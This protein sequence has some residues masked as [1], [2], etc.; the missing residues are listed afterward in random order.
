MA[1]L[2]HNNIDLVQINLATGQHEYYLPQNV[3][4]AAR[5]VDRLRLYLAPCPGMA[6]PVDGITP[7]VQA[8]EADNLYLDL[9][10]A[11]Q[12]C[13]AR[14][15]AARHLLHT[16][17]HPPRV[18]ATLSLPL[19]R[20]Y[21]TGGGVPRGCLLLYVEYGNAEACDLPSRSVSVALALAPG[22]EQ[23]FRPLVDEYIH[24]Q[25]RPV[26]GITVDAAK[27]LYLT[28]R[29][30]TDTHVFNHVPTDFMRPQR[31]ADDPPQATPFLLDAL[32][33]DFDNSALR[34]PFADQA[35]QADITFYY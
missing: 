35:V 8:G 12:A 29:D 3:H 5:R 27:P 33:V 10:G 31:Q 22:A 15:L 24:Q 34:N 21:F 16:A 19:S 28:L 25:P 20:L 17:N 11:D 1:F 9:Y 18:A 26:R 30:E 7:V 4:W 32:D 23:G 13:V 14:R 6:S 2:A